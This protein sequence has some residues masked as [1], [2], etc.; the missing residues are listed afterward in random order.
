MSFM[1]IMTEQKP[2]PK[3]ANLLNCKQWW[4]VCLFYG[5]QEKYYRH[6]YRRAAIQRTNDLKELFSHSF[7][8]SENSSQYDQHDPLSVDISEENSNEEENAK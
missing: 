8:I 7:K 3:S 6:V 5:D 1:M 2:L 4:K